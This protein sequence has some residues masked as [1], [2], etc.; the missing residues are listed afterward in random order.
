MPFVKLDSGILDSTLWVE[1]ECREVFITA[2]LMAEPFECEAPMEQIEVRSL[3]NTGFVVPPGWYGFVPASGP[4]I[5]RRAL[6]DEKAGLAALE[7]LGSPDPGSRSKAF[8]GRRLVR[9]DGGFIVLNFMTY[10]EHDYTAAERMRRYREKKRQELVSELGVTRNVTLATSL[11]SASASASVDV[12]PVKPKPE[13][14]R[15]RK[16]NGATPCPASIEISERMA[17]W[18]VDLGVPAEALQAQTEKFLDHH[19][20]KG[21]TFK[22]W[23]AAWR[24]WMR[25]SVEYQQRRRA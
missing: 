23:D 11:P 12:S 15:A 21:S 22:D 24:T 16:S 5:L 25:N 13:R 8:D 10:R 14:K 17:Q 2:L 9:V 6:V 1:R 19:K 3:K 20:S 18:A 7:R 4:G